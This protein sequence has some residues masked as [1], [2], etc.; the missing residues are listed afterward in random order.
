MGYG[1]FLKHTFV[2]PNARTENTRINSVRIGEILAHNTLFIRRREYEINNCWQA[3][4]AHSC[5]IEV[6]AFYNFLRLKMH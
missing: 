3:V 2:N 1:L 6:L 5:V 4:C